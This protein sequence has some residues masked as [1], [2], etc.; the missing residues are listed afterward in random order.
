[1]AWEANS[2]KVFAAKEL[3]FKASD[4]ASQRRRRWEE[5]SGEYDKIVKL[6][7]VCHHPG[8]V[9]PL[10]SARV[11]ACPGI[12]DFTQTSFVLL[13]YSHQLPLSH[14]LGIARPV[15]IDAAMA[16]RSVGNSLIGWQCQPHS[17]GR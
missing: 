5:L 12:S 8:S 7:H 6:Q 10:S 17:Y 14:V 2:N 15:V 16:G 4:S 9:A 13:K 1:M 3:W 11:I